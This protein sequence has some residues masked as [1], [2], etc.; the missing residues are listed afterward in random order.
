M[1]FS[2]CAPNLRATGTRLDAPA[3]ALLDAPFLAE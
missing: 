1:R 3:G 2:C